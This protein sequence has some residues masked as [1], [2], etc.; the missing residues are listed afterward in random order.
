MDDQAEPRRAA[1]GGP[2]EPEALMPV[3]AA[4]IRHM[5]R[6]AIDLEALTETHHKIL[7]AAYV[8][9]WD[10]VVD[11]LTDALM[12]LATEPITPARVLRS[13]KVAAALQAIATQLDAL[14]EQTG[15]VISD[16]AGR[17]VSIAAEAQAA[18]VGSQLPGEVRLA[19]LHAD[20]VDTIVHRTATQITARTRPLSDAG[21]EAVRR[22]LLRGAASTDNPVKVARDMVNLARAGA[23]DLPLWRAEAI[24]RTELNDAARQVTQSWGEANATTLQGWEWLSSRSINTCPACWA[25]DGIIHDLTEPGPYGHANCRCTRMLVTK[26][27]A[28]LGIDL[29][30]PADARLSAQDHFAT[31]TRADQLAIM[32]PARLQ[33][34]ADGAAWDQLAV[35]KPNADW[36]PSWQVTPVRALQ[37]AASG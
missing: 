23:V 30:E 7:F 5:R 31:L 24:S 34:L 13:G 35:L 1:E 12:Q 19:D 28:Q 17:A 15:V 18:I 36:R 20:L 4:T 21:Q 8:D 22:A 16:S 3:T 10:T 33:A 2:Q 11:Q 27:W 6:L 25:Q 29:P 14:A 26:T 37:T 9:A 32:G